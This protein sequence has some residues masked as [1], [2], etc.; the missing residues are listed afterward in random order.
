MISP[1]VKHLHALRRQG[2]VRSRGLTRR[3][4]LQG[5]AASALAIPAFGLLRP[6][7]RA[8]SGLAER[9]IFFYFPDGVPGP[10]QDGEASLWHASGSESSFTLGEA[11]K[12][13]E[14]WK[15]RCLF[16][17]GLSLGATDTGSHPGGAKKLLTA[18]DYGNNESIDQHLSRSVGADAWWRHLSLGVM[19][20]ADN[21]SG[22]K[23]ISYVGPGS[24]L[25]PE[26]N[27]ST[28][29]GL[30][31]GDG[32]G[33][34][35]DDGGEPD[36]TALRRGSVLD[37][38]L[39]DLEE[40]R[41][42][43][44]GSERAKLDLHVEAVR[45]VERR[46]TGTSGS[47]GGTGSCEVPALSDSFTSEELYD[48]A[49][50]PDLLKTQID[51]M[52][53]SMACGLTRVG[54]LQCSHHTSELLMSRFPGTEM[55]DPS[56][57]MRS[58]QASHYGSKHDWNKREFKAFVQQRQYWVDQFAYLLERLDAMPEGD[59]TMLDNSL[60]VLCTEVCDGNT[61][62]HDNMP[63]VVAGGGGGAIHNG[64]LLQYGYERHGKLFVS[65][66]RAMGED[67]WSFGDAAS[68]DLYGVLR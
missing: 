68:G 13:L 60:V 32:G 58:H 14:P 27:P 34:S 59:G 11:L 57:D 31:F 33:S 26:D 47:G 3:A 63:F 40:L 38:N 17:N 36:A 48:P 66:A 64:R 10:S 53:L 24:P 4:L 12:G 7:A 16:F 51:L 42:Q 29:F 49:R 2:L 46:V 20:K 61:H 1:F 45:E 50:F 56:Y 30:L 6:E 21:A 41:A 19:S 9:I 37:A 52:V 44:D 28:A 35:T 39:E 55:Y 54:T 18:T 22:D 67:L 8:A 65:L 15:D 25:S 5:A 62:L 23:L 43:L